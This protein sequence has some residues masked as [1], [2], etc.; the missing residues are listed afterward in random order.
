MAT[1]PL[2]RS[3]SRPHCASMSVE[4]DE[5]IRLTRDGPI[6]TIWL[7]RPTKRNAMNYAMWSR[8]GELATQLG[9]DPLDAGRRG[10]WRGRALLRGCRHH[11]TE[12]SPRSGRGVVLRSRGRGRGS[13]GR[14]AEADGRVHLRRLHRWRMLHRHR[15]RSSHC[16]QRR[17]VRNHPGQARHRVSEW[18]VG[19]GN[20]PARSGRDEAS[21]V[22]WRSHL[23][24]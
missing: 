7:N 21:A 8:L 20:A 15:L 12:R 2:H 9:D 5:P 23:G 14:R 11:G 13:V 16:H 4:S 24:G 19:A 6:A 1:V 10:A 17:T 18:G 3:S 22:H